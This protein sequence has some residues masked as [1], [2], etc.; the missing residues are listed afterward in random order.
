MIIKGSLVAAIDA[1]AVSLRCPACSQNGSFNAVRDVNHVV[2]ATDEALTLGQRQCPN[3]KCGAHVFVVWNQARSV[4]VSYPPQCI[5]FDPSDV[6]PAV[7][8]ALK[9]AI[10]CHANEAWRATAMMVRRTFE[11]LCEHQEA[12][13]ARLVDRMA[14][15]RNVIMLPQGLLDGLDDVRLLGNDAAHVKGKHYADVGKEEAEAAITFAKDFVRNVY[16]SASAA[17]ALD[18]LKTKK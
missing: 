8:D 6:D 10:T 5:D 15:L 12:D 7:A 11:L 9:E 4:E 16:Q 13:G 14:A 2:A 1:Q 18:A 3:T 17:K